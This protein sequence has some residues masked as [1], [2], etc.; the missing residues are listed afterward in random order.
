MPPRGRIS[1]TTSGKGPERGHPRQSLAGIAVVAHT[2]E[3]DQHPE[4]RHAAEVHAREHGCM[5]ILFA[6]D[7]ASSWSEPMPNQWASEGE[8]DRFGDRLSP[9]DLEFLGRSAIAGQVREVVAR[10]GRASAWLPKDKGVEALAEY[11]S[12]QRAHIVFVPESLDSMDELRPL[13]ASSGDAADTTRP[14]I[15]IH[16]VSAPDSAVHPPATG[17]PGSSPS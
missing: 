11:A 8:G 13:L 6:A 17:D 15:E 2:T 9:E 16:V 14:A 4:V 1:V 7:V 3:D 5:L 10:G 12:V